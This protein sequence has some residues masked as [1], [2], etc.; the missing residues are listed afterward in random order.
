MISNSATIYNYPLLLLPDVHVMSHSLLTGAAASSSTLLRW[1]DI[2]IFPHFVSFWKN[3]LFGFTEYDRNLCSQFYLIKL[4]II[5]T[6]C[7]IYKSNFFSKIKQ[8]ISS[9]SECTNEK[10]V[11]TYNHYK[12]HKIFN[13]LFFIYLF[14]LIL[15]CL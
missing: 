14:F 7:Y 5:L 9:I 15:V 13:F 4:L 8:Y 10:A 2:N 3:E 11:K 12:L 6:K 1:L